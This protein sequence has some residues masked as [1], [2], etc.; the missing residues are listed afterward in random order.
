MPVKP[1]QNHNRSL[2]EEST[3][4][5][6]MYVAQGIHGIPHGFLLFLLTS[7][8]TLIFGM[9]GILNL[10]RCSFFMLSGCFC[11][12]SLSMTGNFWLALILGPI[13]ADLGAY[14]RWSQGL[15]GRRNSDHCLGFT[16]A[17]GEYHTK[18]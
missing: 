13:D 14:L 6:E 4:N 18:E 9:M 5:T 2:V 12:Q 17:I 11:L 1:T 15:L 10:A 16:S 3:A 8:F 7:G